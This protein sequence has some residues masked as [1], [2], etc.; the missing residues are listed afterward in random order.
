MRW[1]GCSS[2]SVFGSHLA[3]TLLWLFGLGVHV[4][5]LSLF[6]RHRMARFE[7]THMVPSWFVPPVGVIVAAVS[8]RGPHEGPLF[9]LAV[10]SLYF[11][12]ITY[13]VMLPVM[14]YRFIFAENIAVS[15]MPT[16][17]ILAAPASLSL[18]GYLSLVGDPSTGICAGAVPMWLTLIYPAT[19][20]RFR[21]AIS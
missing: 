15:A 21:I 6:A 16:L 14:L 2:P 5:F 11:G 1:V 3:W 8:Y 7:L 18:A 4:V 13:A 10:A 9:L 20:I 19:S 12:M 17:A